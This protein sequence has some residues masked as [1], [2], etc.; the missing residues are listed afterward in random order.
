MRGFK[1]NML[2]TNQCERFIKQEFP[3]NNMY[4]YEVSLIL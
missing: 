3:H 4:K 2:K 1:K